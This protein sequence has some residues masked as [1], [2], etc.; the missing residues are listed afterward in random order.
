LTAWFQGDLGDRTERM[1]TSARARRRALVAESES[2]AVFAAH[3]S[4]RQDLTSELWALLNLEVWARIFLD[5]DDPAD[6]AI[7]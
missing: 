1:L 3:R 5:G 2:R 6:V 4:G 7:G